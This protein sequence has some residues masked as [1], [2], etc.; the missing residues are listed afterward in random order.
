[1]RILLI[2]A[3]LFL[4]SISLK[5]QNMKDIIAS[6]DT[7]I[8]IET[9]PVPHGGFEGLSKYLRKEMKYPTDAVRKNIKGRVLVEFVIDTDGSVDQST[10]TVIESVFRSIDLEAMRV[11]RNMPKW[12]PGTQDDVP[13]RVRM[14]LPLTFGK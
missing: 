14:V 12:T 11:V 5:A 4:I 13:V 3:G 6:H 7:I 8:V 1:M 10:V 9:P 2:L